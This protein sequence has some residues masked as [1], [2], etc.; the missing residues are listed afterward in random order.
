M[1]RERS[2]IIAFSKDDIERIVRYMAQQQIIGHMF[3]GKLG[4]QTIR[5]TEDGGVEVITK[6]IQGDYTDLPQAEP[7]LEYIP[8]KKK[9]K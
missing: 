3:I 9:N 5:W 1:L 4:E 8:K 6:Y 2:E 7:Q